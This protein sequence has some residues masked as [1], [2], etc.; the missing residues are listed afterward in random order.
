MRVRKQNFPGYRACLAMMRKHNP[1]IQE[2]GF[3][4]LFPHSAEHLD[5]LMAEFWTEKDHGLRR[6]LLE[7]IGE[8]KSAKAFDLLCEQLQS[9]DDGLRNWAL[10][11][12]QK[13]NTPEARQ[14]LFD[15]GGRKRAP[16]QSV[17]AGGASRRR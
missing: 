10:R 16:K 12:L 14:T 9:S 1:Q 13:L 5:E 3:H 2:D 8:A 11:G 7:L 15:V 4:A 17:A 6:W